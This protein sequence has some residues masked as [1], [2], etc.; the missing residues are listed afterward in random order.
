MSRDFA[1][2]SDVFPK[3]ALDV[4]NTSRVK[5][6]Q[7]Q[8]GFTDQLGLK[9]REAISFEGRQRCNKFLCRGDLRTGGSRN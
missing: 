8:L 2:A 1:E 4:G 6:V 5:R 3:E 7:S 9:S